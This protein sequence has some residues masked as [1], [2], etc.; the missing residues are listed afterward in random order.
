LRRRIEAPASWSRAQ[1]VIHWTIAALIALGAAIGIYMV[2]LPF[3]LL[4]QKFIF[5]QLHKTIGITVF[6]L[7]GTQLV[8]HA[9][10]GR[11]AWDGDLPRWQ[12]RAAAT[13]HA[14]L[15]ALLIITPVFGYLT[16]ATAPIGVPTL[17]LGVVPV[18][19]LVGT[20]KFWFDIL[21]RVHLFL[22]L[23]LVALASGHAAA[24]LGHHW[25]GRRTLVRMWRG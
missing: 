22:A 17:F 25:S 1:R 8:L 24:A 2:G 21:R 4:L 12:R 7:A 3:R 23:G 5:Y 11:P 15:F 9:R 6:L 14:A 20:S 13:V 16:A 10:R 19:H 18:P